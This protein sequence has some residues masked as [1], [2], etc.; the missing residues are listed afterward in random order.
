MVVAV[1]V[2]LVQMTKKME[3]LH[4]TG[5]RRQRCTPQ[6]GVGYGLS[7]TK[8]RSNRDGYGYGIRLHGNG[9]QTYSPQPFS[10]TLQQE[11]RNG[12][13]ITKR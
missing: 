2:I 7:K 5:R 12:R 6:S 11:D 3:G 8:T 1:V 10:G 13:G 9:I 4:N